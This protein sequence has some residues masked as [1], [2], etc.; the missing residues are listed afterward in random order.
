MQ[1]LPDG[2][3]QNSNCMGSSRSDSDADD[4][5]ESWDEVDDRPPFVSVLDHAEVCGRDEC[6]S[7]LFTDRF[8]ASI[9]KES[10]Q[11]KLF[12]APELTKLFGPRVIFKHRISC[13]VQS[14]RKSSAALQKEKE[15]LRATEVYSSQVYGIGFFA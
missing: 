2:A 14:S 1:M 11:G 12:K 15:S 6:Y 10:W 7:K 3:A 5:V 8:A 9:S 4:I 13:K